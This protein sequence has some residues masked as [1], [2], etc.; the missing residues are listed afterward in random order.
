M[1][2]I[3]TVEKMKMRLKEIEHY[4]RFPVMLP[5]I[6]KNYISN[7]HKRLL[8]VAESY[9]F[10][11]KATDHLDAEK[12]YSMTEKDIKDQ[13]LLDWINC[14]RLL[15]EVRKKWNPR[16]GHKIYIEINNGL[17]LAGVK[18]ATKKKYE[19]IE[20]IAFTNFFLRPAMDGKTFFTNGYKKTI[21]DEKG[22]KV[23]GNVI[24]ILKPDIILF[25]SKR[26]Y[27]TYGT[28]L[29]EL[30]PNE[31]I[32]YVCHPACYRWWNRKTYKFSKYKLIELL[33]NSFFIL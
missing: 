21:D 32:N 10:D 12:W 26:I 16:S 13:N 22:L 18:S 31:N 8:V 4:K 2:E 20:E 29:K 27:D 33:K 11:K 1:Q 6:G 23:F 9:Y 14:E 17:V 5:F 25:V 3:M 15:R 30:F 19:E 24:S 28:K 7:N